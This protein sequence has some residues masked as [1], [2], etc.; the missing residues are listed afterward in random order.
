MCK[1]TKWIVGAH[2]ISLPT[3]TKFWPRKC[4]FSR[5]CDSVNGGG[6]YLTRHPPDQAGT[7]PLDQAGTPP[8]GRY[9]PKQVHPLGRYTPQT[10]TP[11]SGRYTPPGRYTPQAGT[12]PPLAGTPP[13]GRYTPLAGTP[14]WQVHPPGRYTPGQI[15]HPPWQVHPPAGTPP[16]E[17][18]TLEYGQWSAGV[19]FSLAPPLWYAPGGLITTVLS[20]GLTPPGH[21][22]MIV[23]Y[24]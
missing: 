14:L 8:S 2:F 17:Q 24:D 9:T 1:C 13:L 15:H 10:G 6:E 4:F 19:R 12:P 7:P 20:L 22:T 23:H 21:T 11:P 16:P 18:Q 5:V 3:E